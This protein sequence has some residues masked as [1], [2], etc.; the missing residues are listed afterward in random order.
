VLPNGVKIQFNLSYYLYTTIM[1]AFFGKKK[2]EKKEER[3]TLT[4]S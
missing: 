2:P 1:E 3:E 4:V